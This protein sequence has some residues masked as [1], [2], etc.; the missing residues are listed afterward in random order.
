M[1]SWPSLVPYT[2]HRI[3]TPLPSV[4]IDT[5]MGLERIASVVQDKPNNFEIDTMA[6][7][8]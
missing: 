8:R 3:Y 7:M 2:F 6:P 5:G 4:C 1:N